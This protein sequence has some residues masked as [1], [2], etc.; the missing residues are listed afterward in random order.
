MQRLRVLML[1]AAVL[2]GALAALVT[3][4]A[5]AQTEESEAPHI[6]ALLPLKSQTFLRYAEAV[7]R[8]ITAAATA[9]V[10]RPNVLPVVVYPTGDDPKDVIDTYDLAIRRGAR[11]VIGPLTKNA[12]QAVATSYA[13]SVPTLALS[14]PDSEVL[15]PDGM[16]AFGVQ[17][18]AE[19][20]QVARIAQ[21]TGKRRVA[22][23]VSDNALSKRVGQ[24]FAEEWARSG[25]LVVDQHTHTTDPGKLKRIRDAIVAGGV[26]VIFFAL[27][28]PKARQVRPYLGKSLPAFG[29]SQIYSP[30]S[31]VLGQH[32]LNGI[33]FV[34]M[35]WLVSPDHAA[36]MTYERQPGSTMT[37]EQERFYALGIDAW[38]LAHTLLDGGYTDLGMMD[39]VSGYL[40]PGPAHVFNREAAVVQFTQSGL[41]P[42]EVTGPR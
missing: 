9:E 41:R 22:I 35:P 37:F 33:V 16:Y 2:Y 38:R 30:E 1:L 39:G 26:D 23:F 27:D 4:A 18:E 28:G 21:S 29:T 19:A 12:V 8:G 10:D 13:V 3:P 14:V 11:F 31:H 15:L 5:R 24:A 36:V 6:A 7:R 40:S 20:R 32:D 25:R 17:M 42:F 34:D